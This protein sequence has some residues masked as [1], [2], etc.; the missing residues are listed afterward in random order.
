MDLGYW[1]QQHIVFFDL[2]FFSKKFL[3]WI[4][5]GFQMIFKLSFFKWFFQILQILLITV[6]NVKHLHNK[7]QKLQYQRV[8]SIICDFNCV[9]FEFSN[10]KKSVFLFWYFYFSRYWIFIFNSLN[11]L[12]TVKNSLLSRFLFLMQSIFSVLVILS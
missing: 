6:V 7:I 3:Y 10:A 11:E 2:F 1:I 5:S 4:I 9:Q 8:S 12:F